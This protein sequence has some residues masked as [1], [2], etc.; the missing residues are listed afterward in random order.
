M[1]SNEWFEAGNLALVI[2]AGQLVLGFLIGFILGYAGANTGGSLAYYLL[3]GLANLFPALV[4][5]H[6]QDFY[7]EWESSL[8][9]ASAVV[10]M[11]WFSWLAVAIGYT[12]GLA[13][14]YRQK[15]KEFTG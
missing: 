6:D 3:I 1:V 12:G 5:L 9:K 2:V 7:Q 15:L 11:G 14:Y 13:S 8:K 10:F 4:V